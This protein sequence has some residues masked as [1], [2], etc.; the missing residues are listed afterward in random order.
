MTGLHSKKKKNYGTTHKHTDCPLNN[1]YRNFNRSHQKQKNPNNYPI[2]LHN[3]LP[4]PTN[5]LTKY[6]LNKPQTISCVGGI[7]IDPWFARQINEYW[8]YRINIV[9]QKNGAMWGLPKGHR[10]KKDVTLYKT[11]I[12]ELLEET[13][14]DFNNMN[15]NNDYFIYNPLSSTINSNENQYR[16]P[17]YIKQIA[18]YIIV[19]LKK[20]CQ[21]NRLKIDEN[22]ISDYKWV[23][24]KYIMNMKQHFKTNRT[25]TKEIGSLLNSVCKDIYEKH[26]HLHQP[27]LQYIQDEQKQNECIQNEYMQDKHILDND[28]D[29]DNNNINEH[30]GKNIEEEFNV[31]VEEQKQEEQLQLNENTMFTL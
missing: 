21:L 12:R 22:E 23:T 30:I 16:N 15:E 19:L 26:F 29:D 20:S 9:K 27:K 17:I 7:I 25:L 2:Q 28:G 8:F 4:N 5:M 24:T 13:G 3:Q 31:C 14:Y 6:C 18:F 11:A 10:E 1:D